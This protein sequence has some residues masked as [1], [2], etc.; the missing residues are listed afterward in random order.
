L[1]SGT[2]W[3]KI[4]ASYPQDPIPP[5]LNAYAIRVLTAPDPN[6][7]QGLQRDASWFFTGPYSDA[8]ESDD[9]P[10]SP[11]AVPMFTPTSTGTLASIEL[12]TGAQA[13]VRTLSSNSDVDWVKLVLP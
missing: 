13:L 5:E 11:P 7:A 4:A 1:A 10:G 9:S 3:I 12:G 6:V 8:Y 2:Y